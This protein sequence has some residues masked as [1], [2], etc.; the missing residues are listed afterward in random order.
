MSVRPATMRCFD[1]EDESGHDVG[2]GF[3]R[4]FVSI[5]PGVEDVLLTAE[6]QSEVRRRSGLLA[7][8]SAGV[9]WVDP[10]SLHLT[11]VFIGAASQ[12]VCGWICERVSE[13]VGKLEAP[14]IEFAGLGCFPGVQPARV[15]WAGVR[16][17]G[18][19]MEMQRS[20]AE[21]LAPCQTNVLRQEGYFPHVTLARLSRK[22]NPPDSQQ[23]NSELQSIWQ[24]WAASHG[25][26]W[27]RH[28]RLALMCSDPAKS[29]N[30]SQ[31]ATFS[32]AGNSCRA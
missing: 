15:I 7:A 3:R 19:L 16:R 18:A 9:R 26:L 8:S 24:D 20:L 30:Y 14:D 11:V 1:K 28:A 13:T 12:Q 5:Q 23:L 25:A 31:V 29:A 6:L 22:S 2:C 17:Q 4:L 32:F 27:W 21:L 10:A